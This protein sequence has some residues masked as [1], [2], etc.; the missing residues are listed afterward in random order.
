MDEAE[1]RRAAQEVKDADGRYCRVVFSGNGLGVESNVCSSET[2]RDFVC[3]ITGE[4]ALE[5]SVGEIADY[6]SDSLN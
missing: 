1:I 6:I 4:S 3:D 5:M 2:G